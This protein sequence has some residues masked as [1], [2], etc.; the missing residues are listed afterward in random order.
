MCGRYA[1]I[2]PLVQTQILGALVLCG[3]AGCARVPE[4]CFDLSP[5]SRLPAWTRLPSGVGRDQVAVT[6]CYYIGSEGGTATFA[7]KNRSTGAEIGNVTGKVRDLHPLTT[8]NSE[9]GYPSYE[10]IAVGDATDVVEHRR[11]EPIFYVVDDPSIRHE[12]G[13]DGG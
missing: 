7:L 5:T 13:V 1:L 12:L 3:L 10:V 4:S 9:D 2:G 8:K 11:R 6:M